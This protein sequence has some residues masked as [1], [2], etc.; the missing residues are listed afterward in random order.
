MVRVHSWKIEFPRTLFKAAEPVPGSR[1][2]TDQ[3]IQFYSLSSVPA[4]PRSPE[5][6]GRSPAPSD[7]AWHWVTTPRETHILQFPQK[8]R[9]SVEGI[10]PLPSRGLR[11]SSDGWDEHTPATRQQPN[12]I[13]EPSHNTLPLY[14][15]PPTSPSGRAHPTASTEQKLLCCGKSS[16]VSKL[17]SI[18]CETLTVSD[19]LCSG[20]I[21]GAVGEKQGS[22]LFQI[23]S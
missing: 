7:E 2:S 13:C 9:V 18:N 15:P 6:E 10:P 16:W 5:P 1:Q 4:A 23:S 19:L 11:A 3:S 21:S 20:F 12:W 14:C 22:L 8:Q 17:T